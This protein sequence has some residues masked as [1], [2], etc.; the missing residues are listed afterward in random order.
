MNDVYRQE[1][2]DIYKVPAH[3]GKMADPS[4]SVSQNN[5]MCG[6]QLTLHLDI[7]NWK[8]A[9]IRF[10]ANAC[11]VSIISSEL[12]AEALIGKSIEEARKLTKEQFLKDIDL[13]L[14]TSRVKCATL[15]LSALTQALEDY[16]KTGK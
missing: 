12:L 3:K 2:M 13:N 1:L 11:A 8:I 10:E 15:V 16:E 4:I 7:K 6:D 14:T 9:D 5:P